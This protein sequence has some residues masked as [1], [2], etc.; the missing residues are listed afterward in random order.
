MKAYFLKAGF[1]LLLVILALGFIL[2][3]HKKEAPPSH[4]LTAK[5][6]EF[7]SAPDTVA[8]KLDKI[9]ISKIDIPKNM[10]S[11]IIDH[12]ERHNRRHVK[13][14]QITLA[15]RPFKIILGFFPE[16]EFYVYDIKKEFMFDNS[17]TSYNLYSYHKIE[18]QFFEFMLIEEGTKIA[19]RPYNGPLGTIKLGKGGR[20]LEKIGFRGLLFNKSGNSVPIETMQTMQGNWPGPVEQC[21]I[22]VGDYTLVTFPGFHITY[23]NLYFS[24]SNYSNAR[25]RYSEKDIIYP[26]QIRLDE[27]YVLDFSNEPMVIFSQPSMSKT[28]FSRGDVIIFNTKLID[29]KLDIMIEKL[30]DTSVKEDIEVKDGTGKLVG[31]FKI[32]KSLDPNV[33]ISRADGEVIVE[34][35]SSRFGYN[36]R[37]PDDLEINGDEEELTVTVT[38]ETQKLYGNVSAQ[39]KIKIRK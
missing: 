27:P 19:A 14:G 28:T 3:G 20:Q 33:V 6:K 36:W 25:R 1:V 26:I 12:M 9:K 24:I 31:T 11:H 16:R 34:G 21:R 10:A 15:N 32:N 7:L 4:V 35:V 17:S 39:R 5:E 29:P 37:V 2:I 22:P 8:C 23:D 13:Q 38:Y 18:D 30:E